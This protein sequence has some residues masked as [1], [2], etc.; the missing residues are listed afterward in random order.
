MLTSLFCIVPFP[1]AHIALFLIPDLLYPSQCPPAASP[2][3]WVSDS[4][5]HS[6]YPFTSTY[7][8]QT[9]AQPV[10]FPYSPAK[11]HSCFPNHAFLLRHLTLSLL[12]P[13]PSAWEASSQAAAPSWAP[14]D[15]R[16]D[17]RCQFSLLP[18]TS[19]APLAIRSTISIVG[20]NIHIFRG[21]QLQV[22]FLSFAFENW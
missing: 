20:R 17:K 3:I 22:S 14:P 11:I 1:T 4:H 21:N 6:Q 16:L 8:F 2:I 5:V 10:Q 12:A 9:L 7:L 18:C 13:E 19:A 15:L